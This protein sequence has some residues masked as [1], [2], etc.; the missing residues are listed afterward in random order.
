MRYQTCTSCPSGHTSSTASRSRSLHEA[1]SDTCCWFIHEMRRPGQHKVQSTV[2]RIVLIQQERYTFGIRA[3]VEYYRIKCALLPTCI[4][5]MERVVNTGLSRHA[6]TY[7]G[8][9]LSSAN[10]EKGFALK[11][12][13]DQRNISREYTLAEYFYF[14]KF[15]SVC[16]LTRSVSAR[17]SLSDFQQFNSSDED[18]LTGSR[19]P[20]G[21]FQRSLQTST[22]SMLQ[23]VNI[24]K[25]QDALTQS[26]I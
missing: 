13:V 9:S 8:M 18:V 2:W 14:Q 20:I 10:E 1:D 19:G 26:G 11:R 12:T 24:I 16:G 6:A 23:C 17:P 25:L 4:L 21:V 15:A 5:H 22:S 3:T 7:G